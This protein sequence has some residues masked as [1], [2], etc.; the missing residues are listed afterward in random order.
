MT[1]DLAQLVAFAKR[2]TEAWCSQ[3]PAGVAAFSRRTDRS[4]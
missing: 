2:Y 3:D 1:I 4:A